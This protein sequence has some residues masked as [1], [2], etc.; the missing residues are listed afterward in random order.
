MFRIGE[1][2]KLT[3]V[4]IR[5]LRY[6]DEVGLLKPAEVDK[7]TGHRMY[8]VT[9]IPRLKRILYLRDS[10]FNVSEIMRAL[11]MND[12]LLLETLDK[13]RLEII[14]A[15]QNEQEKLRKIAIAKNE[16]I[17]NKS[18]LHYNI[19]IKAIPEYQVLSLRRIV[20]TYYS[21]GDLWNELSAFA[22][23]QKIDI[24]NHSFS[25]YHDTEYKEQNVDIELCV[26]VSKLCK[27]IAPFCFR[28]I[29]PVP[30]M[31][32]T[33]VYGDFSN[34]KGAYIAF[35]EWLQRNSN[36]RMS[37]PMRQIVHRGAWNERNPTKYLTEIQIP[38]E[39]QS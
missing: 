10:G 8:S 36:Y 15:I 26:S 31:A 23:E 17:E 1:F 9:Q 20:P 22:K 21:E 35:A 4:S 5:M 6:Y 39:F 11:E 7:W 27:D 37:N 30:M 33:M 13:K 2:S 14:A 3:Q 24:S 16:I 38:L 25:V 19:S 29:E 12:C 28:T 32:C 18:E 34:I